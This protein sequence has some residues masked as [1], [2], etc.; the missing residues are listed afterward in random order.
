MRKILLTGVMGPVILLAGCGA[1]PIPA[2]SESV[3]QESLS[4]SVQKFSFDPSTGVVAEIGREITAQNS[5]SGCVFEIANAHPS[6]EV[7]GAVKVNGT[8]ICQA[9]RDTYILTV[10]I[11]L[12]KCMDSFGIFCSQYKVGIPSSKMITPTKGATWYNKDLNAFVHC[13][14]SGYYRGRLAFRAVN[15]QGVSLAIPLAQPVGRIA[16]VRCAPNP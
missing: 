5:L 2:Q 10:T 1:Q 7:P 3:S 6:S 15:P 12:E 4:D 9:S 14:V 11:I 16:Y 8:G 13:G